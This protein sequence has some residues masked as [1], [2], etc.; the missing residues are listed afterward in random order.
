[1]FKFL[2]VVFVLFFADVFG[3]NAELRDFPYTVELSIKKDGSL[4]EDISD[5]ISESELQTEIKKLTVFSQQDK[6]VNSIIALT[7]RLNKDTKTIYKSLHIFGYYNAKV[8]YDI[9]ISDDNSVA[10]FI[11]IDAKNK[12][13]LNFSIKF[14]DQDDKFNKYYSSILKKKMQ[15]FEGVHVGNSKCNRGDIIFIK[16]HRVL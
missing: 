5:F 4:L 10:V 3:K 6:P 15:E 16:K 2:C 8:D 12:F 1:M 13:D 14:I 11:K 9:E 7:D